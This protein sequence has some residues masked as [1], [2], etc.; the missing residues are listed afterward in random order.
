MLV[1]LKCTI[2]LEGLNDIQ[3]QSVKNTIQ[4]AGIEAII[5]SDVIFIESDIDNSDGFVESLAVYLADALPDKTKTV[6]K[7][8]SLDNLD[9]VGDSL[10][11]YYDIVI[12]DSRAYIVPYRVIADSDK[13][14][15]KEVT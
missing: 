5:R 7:V 9:I 12:E 8:K 15:Y 4:D 3:M 11:G 1:N 14:L 2:E 6:L 10:D 13:T